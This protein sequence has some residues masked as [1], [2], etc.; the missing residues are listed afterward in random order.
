MTRWGRSYERIARHS[1]VTAASET[2][3]HKH[4]TLASVIGSLLEPSHW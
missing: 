3:P 2:K 4:Q 1:D